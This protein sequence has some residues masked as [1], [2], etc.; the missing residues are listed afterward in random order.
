MTIQQPAE[1]LER[2]AE[3]SQSAYELLKILLDQ[4]SSPTGTVEVRRFLTRLR[5]HSEELDLDP[6]DF[7]D[8]YHFSFSSLTL[9][10][11]NLAENQLTLVQL[12]SIFTP[13]DWSFTFYEG[14]ARYPTSEFQG[15]TLAELGCGNGWISIAFAK[16][17]LPAKIFGLDINPRAIVCARINL[18]LNAFDDSGAPLVDVEGKSL[19]DRVEFHTS[20][21]LGYVITKNVQ[22]DTIIGCIPQVLSPEPLLANQLIDEKADDQFLYSLSN[23]CEKQGYIEDQFGLGLIARALEES[24]KVSK[25]SSK[26]ILNMGGRPGASVLEKLFTR[27]GFDVRKIWSTKVW[28]AEDT[29]INPLVEIEKTTTHRFEFFTSLNSDE[30]IYAQTAQAYSEKGGRIAH[31]LSVYEARL[32]QSAPIK[33]IFKLITQTGFEDARNA[34]DLSFNDDELAD[35][36]LNFVGNISEWLQQKPNLPY[37]DTEGEPQLRRQIA[38]FF[39]S[40][41]RIPVTA[42]SIFVCPSRRSLIKNYIQIFQ[43]HLALVGSDLI[44]LLRKHELNQTSSNLNILEAPRRVDEICKLIE[45]LKPS[46][47]I[48][49][50]QDFEIKTIDSFIRLCDTCKRNSCRLVIDLSQQ[51]ELSSQQ[52]THGLLSYLAEHPLPKHTSLLFGLVR[53]KVYADLELCFLISENATLLHD[54]TAAAE[55]TYSRAPLLTQKY[56]SKIFADLLNFQLTDLRKNKNE[57]LRLPEPEGS[58]QHGTLPMFV[59]RAFAHPSIITST[60]ESTHKILRLDYGENSLRSPPSVYSAIMDSFLRK[61]TTLPDS[62]AELA[63]LKFAAQRFGLSDFS[64][65]NVLIGDGVA[66]LF[67]ATMESACDA[68]QK[69]IIPQGA[70]GYFKASCDFFNV[71]HVL[72]KTKA[73]DKFKVTAQELDESLS[74]SGAHWLYL[75]APIVNPTGAIYSAG[76]LS[77]LIDVLNQHKCGLILDTIFSGLEFNRKSSALKLSRDSIE[78]FIKTVPTIVMGGLSK[79]F[80]CGGLRLGWAIIPNDPLVQSIR[81]RLTSTPH[82]TVKHAA[83]KIYL[84]LND[85]THPI[86]DF[87]STQRSVLKDRCQKLSAH[88]TSLG[89][90]VV[91]SEG[92]LFVCACPIKYIEQQ[93]KTSNSELSFHYTD[94]ADTIAQQIFSSTGVLLNNSTWTG[95]P[96]YLRFVIST[97]DDAFGQALVKLKEFDTLWQNTHK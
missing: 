4:A 86:H 93:R 67:A 19:F 96:G 33:S 53:N 10:G 72:L 17:N 55:L 22:L 1:F 83:K 56:Y 12:P 73:Q 24:I 50:L 60:V 54:L 97:D 46:L 42:K 40:Y 74:L 89:W 47:V 36:K 20:D 82:S 70:Y 29:D 21:L 64:E 6:S 39:R 71:N 81:P 84:A 90:E 94:A 49:S 68:G 75:N 48:T 79:E 91:E 26:V 57:T 15:K 27:R 87:L 77:D 31:S 88:L 85:E 59:Q 37:S 35:E 34:L 11:H 2:C 80:A 18:I 41:W 32:R 14:L 28:Q 23:Y 30:P 44:S 51:F 25:P 95:L 63:I 78:N 8:R 61:N 62:S 43:P 69:V 7:S 13:E 58:T 3:S 76:E 9:D 65:T 16:K 38:Q 66:P 45:K 5:K 52:S 92:G